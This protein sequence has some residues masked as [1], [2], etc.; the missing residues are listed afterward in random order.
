MR[1]PH[2]EFTDYADLV[3]GSHEIRK[4]REVNGETIHL[5]ASGHHIGAA[6]EKTDQQERTDSP[7]WSDRRSSLSLPLA[8]E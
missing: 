6:M 2:E 3:P 8:L 4:E 7:N 1:H 5:A